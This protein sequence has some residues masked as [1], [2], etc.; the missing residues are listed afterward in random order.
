MPAYIA[1]PIRRPFAIIRP[2]LL[3]SSFNAMDSF[4]IIIVVVVV[5]TTE[6]MTFIPYPII[7]HYFTFNLDHHWYCSPVLNRTN[8]W[9]DRLLNDCPF[10]IHYVRSPSM[11]TFLFYWRCPV[12]LF[13]IL[14][15]CALSLILVYFIPISRFVAERKPA[16]GATTVK[17]SLRRP[18]NISL[19]LVRI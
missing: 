13:P 14:L 6:W 3:P 2:D 9:L 10:N 1:I 19:I 18:D 8:V 4:I 11:A 7:R 5:Y 16:V 15:C 17:Q 12:W